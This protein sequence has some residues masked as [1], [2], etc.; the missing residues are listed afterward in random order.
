[1]NQAQRK[2]LMAD[3]TN[4]E[5]TE[6]ANFMLTV[7]VIIAN[8]AEED[9]MPDLSAKQTLEQ[10]NWKLQGFSDKRLAHLH[11]EQI[12]DDRLASNQPFTEL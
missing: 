1:M 8:H 9:A 3:L 5:R 7:S 4:D 12:E 10:L 11:A 6:L 2:A